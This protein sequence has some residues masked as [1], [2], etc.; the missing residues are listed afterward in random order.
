MKQ[1]PINDSI[2]F[3]QILQH[4]RTKPTISLIGNSL[5]IIIAVYS[6]FG[7]LTSAFTI[8]VDMGTL[9][10]I[11][12]LNALAVS[13]LAMLY[14]GKGI[15]ML[16]PPVLLLLMLRVTE[17]IEGAKWVAYRVTYLFSEWISVTVLY[18]EIVELSEKREELIDPTV[19]IAAA[20]MIITFLLAYAICMRRS[21]FFTFL[22]TAP[23]L[24]LT[25]V[26]TDYQADIIYFFGLIVVYLTLLIS[27]IY[28]PDDY[29]KRG[30]MFIPS[31]IIASII[32]LF[33][34]IINPHE[35][36]VR[37]YY[38]ST[39]GNQFRY[40]ASRMTRFG[41]LWYSAPV[42]IAGS[43]T[44]LRVIDGA[45]WRFDTENVSVADAGGRIITDQSL[46]EVT[47][48]E[49]G[50]FY[51]RGYSMQYFDGRSWSVSDEDLLQQFTEIPIV[52]DSAFIESNREGRADTG[53]HITTTER[54]E[55]PDGSVSV[56][57]TH[58]H[59]YIMEI[60]LVNVDVAQSMPA[61]IAEFYTK[62]GSGNAPILVEMEISRTGDLT[63]GI[64][65]R[66][67]YRGVFLEENVIPDNTETFYYVEGSVHRLA[68]Y[69]TPMDITRTYGTEETLDWVESQINVPTY[70][71]LYPNEMLDNALRMYTELILRSGLY[72]QVNEN[73]AQG[74][75]QLA[76]DA[77][78]DP[79]ADRAIIADA[80]ANYI[81][82]SGTYTLM[83]GAIPEDEDFALFFLQELQE[84]YCIHYATA[85]VLMLRSLGVP[86]RFVSGYVASIAHS[87]AGSS[88]VLTDRNAHAWAEVFYEDAGWL[89]LEVT[90]SSEYSYVPTPRPHNPEHRP[91]DTQNSPPPDFLD[92]FEIPPDLDFPDLEPVRQPPVTESNNVTIG[93]RRLPSWII[94]IGITI[95][96]IALSVAALQA[97]RLILRMYRTKQFRQKNTNEAV[98]CMWRHV[99]RL[100]RRESV[101]ATE[102]ED[103]ALKAKFSQHRISEEERKRMISY[104]QRLSYEIYAGKDGFG[105]LWFKYVRALY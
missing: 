43:D 94:D 18:P 6:A 68:R 60:P 66:P 69:L 101:P 16:I 85:A 28:S 5:L 9:F 90:P 33:A 71:R 50:T 32:M 11:W 89:Y 95:L 67:Y 103:L 1:P 19:F 31:F 37:S 53:I 47:A 34:F 55:M 105:R 25:F 58:I 75:R 35:T 14:R 24:I 102:I 36:Y 72:T 45:V 48:S 41:N 30:L 83:P 26:I 97:R 73:T 99:I 82:S 27:G 59:P 38:A 61:F 98:I 20:G 7:A 57:E 42:G 104:M 15:L 23:V 86:A 40:V 4:P 29:F 91:I 78:I 39:L 62:I 3:H 22:F 12:L 13:V 64:S 84:G 92:E 81:M 51:L 87:E 96:L 21:L 44:W 52:W 70:S 100:S 80:V 10:L 65:Y 56:T 77:S 54:T 8:A 63:D 49:P 17:I 74:L 79:S 88:V 2:F 76:F 46:L 93:A